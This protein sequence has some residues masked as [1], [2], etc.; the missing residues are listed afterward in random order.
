[1]VSQLIDEMRRYRLAIYVSNGVPGAQPSGLDIYI[2]SEKQRSFFESMLVANG[3]VL[4]VDSY[5]WVVP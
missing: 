3:F 5:V 2:N 1:M 4:G